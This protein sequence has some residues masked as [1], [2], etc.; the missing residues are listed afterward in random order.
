MQL[1]MT[2]YRSTTAR[3]DCVQL[4]T[5][6]SVRCSIKSLG[7]YCSTSVVCY[8]NTE[9]N[10]FTI[11]SLYFTDILPTSL[12]YQVIKSIARVVCYA[13]TELILLVG[14]LQGKIE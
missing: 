9:V 3:R 5:V 6:R 8:A 10:R 12:F 4:L 11:M 14:F 1:L 7:Y 13:N 2:E